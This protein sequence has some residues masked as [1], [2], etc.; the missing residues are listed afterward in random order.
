LH[1]ALK[2]GDVIRAVIRNTAVNQDGNT[3]GITLPSAEA[4]EALIRRVYSDA[5]LDLADTA[6]VEAHGTGTPAGDP[7]EAAALGATFGK[8]RVPGKPLYIGS[9][10]SNVG[11]L[12]G[13]S[14]LVQVVKGVM[15][16]EKGKI[17]PSIWYE[18]PNPRIPMDEWNLAVPT[19]LI[20]WPADGLRRLSINSFGY[21]GTNAHCILDDAY[22][23]L[24]ARR[25]VGDHN[26]LVRGGSPASTADS[27]VDMDR[28][29]VDPLALGND[30]P[31]SAAWKSLGNHA[32]SP[33]PYNLPP[34]PKLLVW[35]SHEQAGVLRTSQMYSAYL[36]SKL[37]ENST[38][39]LYGKEE[40]KLLAKF[41]RTLAAR[42]SI[43]PWKSFSIAGSCAEAFVQLE[44]PPVVPVR[45]ANTKRLPKIALVFTGQG[46]QW[47]AMGRELFSLPVFR[48]S[49]EAASKFFVKIGAPWSLISELFC[50]SF[51]F[52]SS[53]S[54]CSIACLQR[55]PDLIK[56]NVDDKTR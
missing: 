51:F 2:N 9:I 16:L 17:P 15:M 32:S 18:K 27:G 52:F 4:Q 29:D 8:A 19:E 39:G 28:G 37:E 31:G 55:V 22:H 36:S 45:S 6:Y 21:G 5:G 46:A 14:G 13:G 38:E 49:L 33:I 54:S 23:Y 48:E 53:P 11:H 35:T 30:G 56:K 41:A 43:F 42:R 47:Q 40:K 50:F 20:D 1:L 24:K 10:K 7:V 12:E 44:S 3:P 25:L 26:V 34:Q